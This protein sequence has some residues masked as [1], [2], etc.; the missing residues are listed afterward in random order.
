[1][2]NKRT[3]IN[4]DEE[5]IIQGK[6]TIEGEFEQ[7][8]LIKNT[9]VQVVE[10][11]GEQLI[12]NSDGVAKT[13]ANGQ[14]ISDQVT[15]ASVVLHSGTSNVFL[16]YNESNATLAVSGANAVF[17]N[18][19]TANNYSG[20]IVLS[21]PRNFTISGD[22]VAPAQAFDGS[23][24]IDLPLTLNTV[25]SNVGTFG[26][27]STALT[28]TVNNKGLLTSVSEA[29]IDITASQV[30]DFETAA[31][32]LF[33]VTDA[34]GDGSL[35]YSNG[36]FT[37]TGPNQAEAN[38]R[39]DARLSGG[40]GIAYNSG[41]ISTVDA[42]IVH[43][44]LSGFVTNEHIDHSDVD[45]TAGDGLSG[46]GDITTSR[47]FSVDS[48]VVRTTG[49]QSIAGEKTFTDQ[50]TLSAD[51]IPS[52]SNTY[53]I[54]S[55]THH[56]NDVFANVVHAERLD[57]GDADLS[58]IHATFYAGTPTGTLVSA[59]ESIAGGLIYQ[60]KAPGQ[61]GA[62]GYFR[63]NP[64][65]GL[66]ISG[67]AVAVDS[68][69]IRTTGNQ[70]LAGTKTF[71]GTVDLSGATV[72]SFTVAGN[73]DVTGNVNS[74]NYVD[75]Q[76]QN[77]EIIL[78]SNVTVGQDA[79]IKNERGSSGNDTYLKWNEG[80]DRWQFSNDGSTDNDMLLLSDFSAVDSGGDGSFSYNSS[81][82]AFTYTGPSASEVRAHFSAGTGINI[83]AG[84]ISTNDNAIVHDDLSGFVAN[85]HIDHSGVSVLA[86][87]GL[88][89]GGDITASRTLDVVGGDG[90]TVNANDI[91]VD[92]TVVRTTGNQSLAG[93]KTFTGELII[94]ASAAT[95]NG[96]IYYDNAQSKAFIYVGGTIQEI[97]PAVSAGTVE[98]VGTTG[99]NI[100]AGSRTVGNVTYQGIKSIDA[101]T[102]LDIS[103]A[104]NVISIAGNV[105]QIRG[106]F[107]SS[108]GIDYDS[109]TGAFTADSA[110][111]RSLFSAIDSGGD[112]SFG[113][114]SST[115]A[116][117]YTGP[118]ATE[119][120][121]H[122]SAGT[123]INIVGGVISTT[124]DDYDSWTLQTDSGGG[125]AETITSSETVTFQGGTNITVTNVGNVVTIRND[126]AADIESVTAG[127]GLT[128]GGSAGAITLSLDESHARGL[129]SASGNLSYN[130]TTGVMSFTERT[131]SEVRGLISASGD[132][133]Y[134][135][136][137][138][139]VSFT[140]RTDAEVR[141][142]ISAS[143]DLSYN[144]TTGVVSYTEPTMYADSDARSAISA[145]G[146]LSY[147]SGTGVM[148]F[149]ERTDA[150]VRGLISAGGDLSYNSTTGV[151][152]YTRG[153]G[154]I[155][156]VTAGTNLNGG[157][158]SGAVT[159]NLD[160]TLTGMTA[161][162][163]SGTVTANLFSGTATSARYADL[164]EKY[165]S[166][167][168]YVAGTV[169]VFGGE[170]EITVTNQHND[171]RVAGIISTD[172][173][174]MMNSEA[175]G[176]YVALRGRVPCK[177]IG[178]VRK[179]DVL[180]TSSRPGFAQA[181]ANPMSVSACCIV[182]KALQDL[183]TP[184]ES[185]IEVV[186]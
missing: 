81:T 110:E 113:Y 115:G 36:V 120:R 132:I 97:T 23:G 37:Y 25:N 68:T 7:R 67:N 112:G 76:V 58:D 17:S 116:F 118:S 148:S 161:A 59:D 94:P 100:F 60:H 178:P 105:T 45:L 170:K 103:E 86:G 56:V 50:I 104:S 131:D 173:A 125:S 26:N 85:E 18:N 22:G 19:I 84:S 48:T 184:S 182:G 124:A 123:G 5:L 41:V 167:Q 40:T 82:G 150:E 181:C 15:A 38:A 32:A 102:Y 12:V 183:E 95:A 176:Q 172:P 149:T 16:T 43:D 156:S 66:Q 71:T 179:G 57:L 177:V 122:F 83:S 128:G 135:D 92:A 53:N 186:V 147:N 101:G 157:G 144:S 6:L 146:D 151:M 160:T 35:S 145:S 121:A 80:T 8:D 74:L 61:T 171:H 166:D 69:V 27:A 77:S 24:D 89:G 91:E 129:I 52:T 134:N 72:P 138:G 127:T 21:V 109:S 62:G 174:Y 108:S 137:T 1:M 117:T 140:E 29:A 163:F 54:G 3:Y 126:N 158:T 13:A 111:I 152:S 44:D 87:Q 9:V 75:L 162:T 64:G 133:S 10:Y 153:P 47:S 119:V 73:L 142:L 165:E 2:A 96:A 164:A 107:T 90:I 130:S 28:F 39:V 136:S 155:E 34:G 168:N 154:D 114:N 88:T 159:L 79:L 31:E 98:D 139:V 51:I 185:V 49:A 99:I 78:N 106:A 63:V 14:I 143:G 20:N 42:E 4:A 70:S 180:I 169:V 55:T 46:G 93:T 65:D 30:N 33:S 11:D 141:G 175:D